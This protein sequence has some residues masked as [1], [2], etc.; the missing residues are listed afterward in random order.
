MSDGGSISWSPH[1]QIA[2]VDRG[3]HVIRSSGRG[4]KRLTW[5][6]QDQD[7]VFSPN[8]HEIAFTRDLDTDRHDAGIYVISSDGTGLHRVIRGY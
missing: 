8:G 1:G 2:F 3:I 4:A 5:G 6:H 7:P